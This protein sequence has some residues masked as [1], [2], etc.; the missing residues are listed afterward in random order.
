MPSALLDRGFRP[1]FLLGSL[2]VASFTALWVAVLSGW[3]APPRWM[4]A[5]RWHA[6]EMLFG[7]A[8]AAIA[9]FLLTAVPAWTGRPAIRGARLGALVAIWLA[10]R[11]LFATPDFWPPLLVAAVDLAFLPAL[12]LAIAPSIAAARVARHAAFP[13]ILLALA[14]ANAL[15]LAD[16]LG[17][18][19]GVAPTA[20]RA[21]VYGVAAMVTLVGGRIVPVFTTNALLRAGQAVEPLAPGLADRVAL[22]A[23]LAFA[24][25]D[26]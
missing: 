24:L 15:V 11:L 17:W 20:L 19:P 6:H 16:A 7:F 21:S 2:H 9:G 8:S 1:F 4:A 12:A 5:T 18:L 10:G 26:V 22:P 25:L 13:V 3:A 14:G 23:V